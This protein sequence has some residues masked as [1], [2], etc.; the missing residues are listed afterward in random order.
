MKTKIRNDFPLLR[1]TDLIYLDNAATTQ[2]PQAVI[3]A[4]MQFY[5]QTNAPVKRGIYQLAEEATTA[6]EYGRKQVAQFINA[7][8]DEIIFTEGATEGINF[9]ASTWGRAHIKAGD[10]I[11]MSELEHHSNLLPWQA[12]ARE[13]G[14]II[15]YIPVFSDGTLDMAALPKLITSKTKLISVLTVS[16]AIGTHVDVTQIIAHARSVGAK[17]LLDACQSVPHQKTDVKKLDAD[18]LVF[19]GHKLYGP[20]GIGVL[21][22]KKSIQSEVPPYQLGGGMVFEVSLDKPATFATP[23]HCYE[24]GTPPVAQAVGLAASID[25]L[26]ETVGDMDALTA[27]QA[28]LCA[29]FIDGLQ[30]MPGVR[31]LG[32]I[33][34]LKKEGHLVSFVHESIH[35]H[36]IAAFLDSAGI[37]VRAG[38]FC[39]QPLMKRFGI[40]GA[41]RASF[42]LYSAPQEVDALL[43]ALTR[44]FELPN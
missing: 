17:V 38:H 26:E 22:I 24:A 42:A 11:I 23:P 40:A 14:A 37:C 8:P 2:K 16:N 7:D 32:P 28:A 20:T 12:C 34:Q 4:V 36:D 29:R 10:E 27:H 6:Y 21:Y 19:S 35:P 39:A 31:I 15:K 33:D 1:D 25:Y 41:V 44:L 30:Q 9:I 5:T 3:D 43:Q 13:V 18:F